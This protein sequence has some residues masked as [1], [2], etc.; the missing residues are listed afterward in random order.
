MNSKLDK[1]A[2]QWTLN[3]LYLDI[4]DEDIHVL[5]Y[6]YYFSENMQFTQIIVKQ[7]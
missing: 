4:V 3:F 7:Y 6:I 2:Y 5:D 1:K